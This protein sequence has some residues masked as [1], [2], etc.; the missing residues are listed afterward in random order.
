MAGSEWW[1]T[2]G[3]QVPETQVQLTVTGATQCPTWIITRLPSHPPA[4]HVRAGADLCVV[5]VFLSMIRCGFRGGYMEVLNMDPQVKAQ[6]LKML[7]VRLCPPVSGQAAMD[8]I[9]NPPREHEPSY[10]QFTEVGSYNINIQIFKQINCLNVF[11]QQI[12]P[13]A[14]VNLYQ[15]AIQ[16][17]SGYRMRKINILA[18][19]KVY[20][21]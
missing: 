18:D 12:N 8:V 4:V 2:G 17:P 3:G 7:S 14:F 9:V 6:L 1:G 15:T 10:A 13:K 19:V 16:S 20:K 11:E 21:I 5:A